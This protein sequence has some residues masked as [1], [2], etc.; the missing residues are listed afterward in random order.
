MTAEFPEG[1]QGAGP[2]YPAVPT[3]QAWLDLASHGATTCR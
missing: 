1:Y 2:M 3:G